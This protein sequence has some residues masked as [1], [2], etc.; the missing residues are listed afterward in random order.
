MRPLSH[1]TGKLQGFLGDV[2]SSKEVDYLTSIKDLPDSE[3][4]RRIDY[5][6][7]LVAEELMSLSNFMKKSLMYLCGMAALSWY[8]YQVKSR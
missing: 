2:P 3:I 1:T 5:K 6:T 4:I 8:L 7:K